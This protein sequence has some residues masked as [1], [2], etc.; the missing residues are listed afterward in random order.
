M[1]DEANIVIDQKDMEFGVMV[2]VVGLN[3]DVTFLFDEDGKLI[4]IYEV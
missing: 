2:E 3:S 4:E 1:L